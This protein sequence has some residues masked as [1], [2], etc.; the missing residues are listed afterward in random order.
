MAAASAMAVAVQAADTAMA[1]AST[2]VA[3]EAVRRGYT[4]SAAVWRRARRS[5][6]ERRLCGLRRKKSAVAGTTGRPSILPVAWQRWQPDSRLCRSWSTRRLPLRS[7]ST[8][9]IWD[10]PVSRSP[11]KRL[12]RA[13]TDG[14]A[15]SHATSDGSVT[16]LRRRFSR[17]HEEA[18][19][20]T[21]SKRRKLNHPDAGKCTPAPKCIEQRRRRLPSWAMEERCCGCGRNSQDRRGNHVDHRE[22]LKKV[23][24]IIAKVRGELVDGEPLARKRL[25]RAGCIDERSWDPAANRQ[26]FLRDLRELYPALAAQPILEEAASESADMGTALEKVISW[27]SRRLEPQLQCQ[28]CRGNSPV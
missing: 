27:L 8:G 21:D 1:V 26:A 15:S 11:I 14:A 19:V 2:A 20:S 7:K 3:A 28:S 16:K 12:R 24:D 10:C 6:S 23:A 18:D 9:D 25:R 4:A 13:S 22:G 17:T 5:W